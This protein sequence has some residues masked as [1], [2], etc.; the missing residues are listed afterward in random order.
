MNSLNQIATLGFKNRDPWCKWLFLLLWCYQI[1]IDISMRI[2][3]VNLSP[4]FSIVIASKRFNHFLTCLV[5][6]SFFFDMESNQ[7]IGSVFLIY[8]IVLSMILFSNGECKWCFSF[9]NWQTCGGYQVYSSALEIGFL[10]N[11]FINDAINHF[12]LPALLFQMI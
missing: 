4:Y 7:S 3:F 9:R 10:P 11:S 1:Y 6:I 8:Y 2:G 12:I 5:C